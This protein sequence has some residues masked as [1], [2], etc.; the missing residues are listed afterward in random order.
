VNGFQLSMQFPIVI[1]FM[2]NMLN[3]EEMF[4]LPKSYCRCQSLDWML[5]MILFVK[6]PKSHKYYIRDEYMMEETVIAHLII[7]ANPFLRCSKDDSLNI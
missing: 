4:I 3:M 6:L 5:L 2:R 1:V 7:N